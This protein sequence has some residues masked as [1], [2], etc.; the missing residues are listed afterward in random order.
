MK[1]LVLKSSL[2]GEVP[3]MFP[4]FLKHNEMASRFRHYVP[5]SAGFVGVDS[6]GEFIAYGNSTSMRLK[7]REEDTELLNRMLE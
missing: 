7:A 3:I 4:D 1:Y 6:K 2:Y 5:V